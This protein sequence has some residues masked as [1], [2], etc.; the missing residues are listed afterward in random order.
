MWSAETLNELSMGSQ[1]AD[2]E[3][4]PRDR[5]SRSNPSGRK[6]LVGQVTRISGSNDGEM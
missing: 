2:F 5:Q 4:P 1:A 3:L 6:R